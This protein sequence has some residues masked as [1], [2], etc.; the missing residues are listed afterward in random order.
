MGHKT[1]LLLYRSRKVVGADELNGFVRDAVDMFRLMA[2]NVRYVEEY[3]A[4]LAP[5]T[6]RRGLAE[7]LN[8]E[9]PATGLVRAMSRTQLVTRDDLEAFLAQSRPRQLTPALQSRFATDL[10][11]RIWSGVFIAAGIVGLIASC[12]LWGQRPEQFIVG[13]LGIAFATIGGVVLWLAGM[14]GRRAIRILANGI[15]AQGQIESVQE[16]STVVGNQRQ[17]QAHVRFNANGSTRVT[18]CNLYG[19]DA[20]RARELCEDDVSINI[21]FDPSN[22]Q[23]VLITDLLAVQS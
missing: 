3:R 12:V 16:T 8:V 1:R 9:R 4:G 18:K 14:S 21:L 19:G 5:I 10:F 23:R 17:H 15:P 22:P 20:M 6:D 7:A 11:M 2:R 13:G